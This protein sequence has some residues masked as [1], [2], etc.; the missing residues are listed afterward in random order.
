MTVSFILLQL[1]FMLSFIPYG[2]ICTSF[3]SAAPSIVPTNTSIDTTWVTWAADTTPPSISPTVSSNTPTTTPSIIPSNTPSITPTR[4]PS[5]SPTD[6]PTNEPSTAPTNSPSMM[7]SSVPSSAPS[8]NPTTSPSL[9]PTHFPTHLPSAAPSTAPSNAPSNN[10]TI[11]P[12]STPTEDPTN[13]PSL[14]PTL[15]PTRC[16]DD[17]IHVHSNDGEDV[18]TKVSLSNVLMLF[19]RNVYE[20]NDT[21]TTSVELFQNVGWEQNVDCSTDMEMCKIQCLTEGACPYMNAVAQD[22]DITQI[23]IDCSGKYSCV[24]SSITISNSNI[25]FI[26]ITCASYHSCLSMNIK[27]EQTAIEMLTVQCLDVRSCASLSISLMHANYINQLTLKCIGTNDCTNMKYRTNETIVENTT[28]VCSHMHSCNSSSIAIHYDSNNVDQ[29]LS[30]YC[31]DSWSCEG[32]KM[33]LNTLA[34]HAHINCYQAYACSHLF[35]ERTNPIDIELNVYNFSEDI[36]IKSVAA[37]NRLNIVCG[38]EN[39]KRFI[40]YNTNDIM[41]EHEVIELAR[42]EYKYLNRLPCE[43]IHVDCT[44]DEYFPKSCD[45]KYQLN[46]LNLHQM[47]S[48][49]DTTD[50]SCYWMELSKLLTAN[51]SGTCNTDLEFRFVCLQP[52]LAVRRRYRYK[53]Q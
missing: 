12:S 27:I 29:H 44:V 33:H 40:R 51:C 34:M 14:A 53:Q 25:Q 5:V 4:T 37:L 8:G 31:V 17:D 23:I 7:P 20:T 36:N 45:W 28:I 46:Q 10:P 18:T 48:A 39:D 1:T 15:P 38:N 13:A 43:D 50:V 6:Y 9:T 47:M 52:I 2:L 24:L 21:N 42:R 35:F 19:E 41:T 3:P 11:A 30:L 22:A 16:H 26:D 32:A 49:A